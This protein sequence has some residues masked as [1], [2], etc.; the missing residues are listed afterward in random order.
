MVVKFACPHMLHIELRLG[1]RTLA[2]YATPLLL[3]LSGICNTRCLVQGRALCLCEECV[4]Q[5]AASLHY[6]S[7]AIALRKSQLSNLLMWEVRLITWQGMSL[8]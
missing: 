2:A 5:L 3:L 7:C 4:V 1:S 8:L 6:T